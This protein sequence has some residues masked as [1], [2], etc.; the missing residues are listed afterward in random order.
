MNKLG[1]VF[2]VVT[3]NL[4]LLILIGI[5]FPLVNPNNPNEVQAIPFFYG[6]FSTLFLIYQL[7]RVEPKKKLE[8]KIDYNAL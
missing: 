5:H 8:D 7:T 6:L 2:V 1:W 3:S 4:F